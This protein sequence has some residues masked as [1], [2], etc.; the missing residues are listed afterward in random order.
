MSLPDFIIIGAMKSGTSTLHEQL[1]A[2]ADV[3]MT[4]PKEPNFFSDDAVYANGLDW[5]KNLFS[6]ARAGALKGEASTHYTKLP[7]Y[8]QTVE[9]LAAATADV[10]LI[11]V[12]RHPID[13]LVSHYV[14]E[15]TQNVIAAPI[16]DAIEAH[17]E[18]IAYSRY[19][20]QLAPYIERFGKDSI[21]PV[22]FERLTAA[23]DAELK[24][25]GAFIGAKTPFVWRDDMEAANISAERIRRF[26]LYNLIVDNPA[27]TFLRRALVPQA[28]RDRVKGRLQMKE[29]P[30]LSDAAQKCLR[31]IFDEDL[32][33]LSG[34][35]DADLNCACYKEKARHSPIGWL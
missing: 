28:L 35:F 3:F 33:T 23:P 14:H 31:D 7:T 9:R 21:L 1:A 20:Y 13:R 16:N 32:A 22:F 8:P 19:A 18:L 4:T 26:P 5:Y 29:R 34:Y 25:I 15:W 17:P 30:T 6:A 10:K 11:Y 27:A 12:M 2:Q 24:R